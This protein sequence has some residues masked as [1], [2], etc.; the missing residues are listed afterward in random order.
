MYLTIRCV[1]F[2]ALRT[3][4]QEKRMTRNNCSVI[5][6]SDG[7]ILQSGHQSSTSQRTLHI[8]GVGGSG[9][10]SMHKDIINLN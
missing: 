3:V 5:V 2:R 6:A 9:S 4:L 7:V 1:Y 8:T 10:P